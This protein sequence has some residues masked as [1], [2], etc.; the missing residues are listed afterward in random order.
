MDV[1]PL[2]IRAAR[3]VPERAPLNIHNVAPTDS[4]V[5]RQEQFA[6]MTEHAA[7]AGLFVA[8]I[9]AAL[10]VR[11]VATTAL[12]VLPTLSAVMMEGAVR[13]VAYAART[14]VAARLTDPSA[15]ALDVALRERFCVVEPAARLTMCV[16]LMVAVA[17]RRRVQSVVQMDA[18]QLEHLAVLMEV[19]ARLE[20]IVAMVDVADRGDL[21]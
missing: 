18:A 2:V 15:P 14:V 16:A 7:Q 20:L 10:R 5:V 9:I 21:G 1:I 17:V 12:A 8:V 4:R 19:V 11:N 13:R 3:V 6:V